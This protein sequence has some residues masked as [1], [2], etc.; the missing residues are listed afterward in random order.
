[1]LEEGRGKWAAKSCSGECARAVE[2]EQDR[3]RR[4]AG[5]AHGERL[6]DYWLKRGR[7]SA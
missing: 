4:A 2:R 3:R 6:R 5:A 7:M 1:M